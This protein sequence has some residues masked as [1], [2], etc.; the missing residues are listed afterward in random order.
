MILQAEVDWFN[1]KT[2]DWYIEDKTASLFAAMVVAF[3]VAFAWMSMWNGIAD[4]LL[5]CVAWNRRQLHEGEE[6]RIEEEKMIGEVWDYCPQQM[7]SLLPD[8][9]ME[10]AAEH[11]LHAHG[12]GQNG[13]IL[14]AME[15]GAMNNDGGGA[16]DYSQK[17]AGATN[18]ATR[19]WQG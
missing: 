14:A 13:A 12:M 19:I 1:D 8:H 7:R 2:S 16:P 6:H 17:F 4:S 10:P 5:Y 9:E 18:M 15:H 11:G 3:G